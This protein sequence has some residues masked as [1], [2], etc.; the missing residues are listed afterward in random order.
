MRVLVG[1]DGLCAAQTFLLVD[2][3]VARTPARVLASV[4]SS[5]QK[6][7]TFE[8]GKIFRNFAKS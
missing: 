6:K 2:R 4:V 5:K 1:F 8:R 7:Q 3:D